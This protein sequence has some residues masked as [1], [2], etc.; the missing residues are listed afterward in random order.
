MGTALLNA[1]KNG[2]YLSVNNHVADPKVWISFNIL[3]V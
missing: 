1:A 3:C 2:Q